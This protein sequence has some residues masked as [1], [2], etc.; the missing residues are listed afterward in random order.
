[1]PAKAPQKKILP[2]FAPSRLFHLI[3]LAASLHFSLVY[4]FVARH[5]NDLHQYVAHTV[6]P[7]FLFRILPYYLYCGFVQAS[8]MAHLHLPLL[9]PPLNSQ[10]NWFMILLNLLALFTAIECTAS[11]IVKTTALPALR[12]VALG[13]VLCV[14]Y[15]SI[16]AINLS[17]YYTYD[18]TSLAFFA[19]LTL[20]SLRCDYLS[21]ALVLPWAML[22][23]ETSALAILLFFLLNVTRDR[24]QKLLVFSAAMS[25]L[26][27]AVKYA[28]I[29]LLPLPAP[30]T[31]T[32]V[33][34]QLSYNFHQLLNPLFWVS[35]VSL[36]GYLW[37]PLL[38]LWKE[39]PRR[40]RLTFASL[41]ALWFAA[42]FYAGVLRELRVFS[43]LSP[44]LLVALA[45][46]LANRFPRLK[47][48][49]GVE[50]A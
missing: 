3:A 13:L 44:L 24:C 26:A 25:G 14:D 1:M 36:F 22:N 32:L 7:P 38:L 29:H 18:I 30:V 10:E 28:T 15:N 20:C 45:S 33:I 12:W 2:L 31:G 21:F 37:I 19:L 50:C 48:A 27:C 4:I 9:N 35:L 46:G 6:E 49:S 39:I 43:E 11:A 47:Q 23:K 34:N 42:M 41:F 17:L 16:L 8:E 5:M 40:L